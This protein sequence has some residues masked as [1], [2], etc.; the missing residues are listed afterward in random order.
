MTE[1]YPLLSMNSTYHTVEG[2]VGSDLWLWTP[3]ESETVAKAYRT[4]VQQEAKQFNNTEY[5]CHVWVTARKPLE[6]WHPKGFP[7]GKIVGYN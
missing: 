4:V 7:T 2:Y 1:C 5:F 3:H 6:G